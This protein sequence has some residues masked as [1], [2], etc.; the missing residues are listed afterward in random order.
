MSSSINLQSQ[1]ETKENLVKLIGLICNEY[2]LDNT[3]S[4]NIINIKSFLGPLRVDTITSKAKTVDD[5]N[6]MIVKLYGETI[7]S[8]R[9]SIPDDLN[10]TKKYLLKVIK[11]PGDNSKN[12]NKAY[13]DTFSDQK[14][15]F[16]ESMTGI[17]SILDLTPS[18]RIETMK[19]INYQSLFREEYIMID[20]RYQ[21]KVN[22][23]PTK[24]SFSLI[25]TTK[26]KSDHGGV[27]IGRPIKDI[28][29][30]EVYPFTIPYKPVYATFYN[31]ITLSINEWMSNS[32]EAYEGG[33]F[34][35][36][37]D[38]DKIDNN[39][40]YLK[41]VNPT[42]SFSSPVNYVDDF[43]LS[44]GAVF[45]KISFDPDRMFPSSI[46]YTNEYGL[47][48]FEEPHGLV[49]GDLIYITDFN[50]PESARDVAIISEVNRSEGHTIV[51]KDN[52]S[53]LINVDIT[54]VYN[55]NPI[56]SGIYPM[57]EFD[58][59]ALVFFAS[60]RIQIQMKL[61]YLTS[62]N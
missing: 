24:L 7:K 58:Q 15:G 59:K 48:I 61:R 54:S 8:N 55:E 4:T 53:I 21:N 51:K 41:P 14:E 22:S 25:G 30:I 39:L 38:I 29:E 9:S 44:F 43:T 31:K 56:G 33:Q 52:H 2:K 36:C 5:A 32:F 50:T 6:A 62:Y 34:H 60:K 10:S 37:F 23:D 47:F 49:T 20:S 1:I 46:D 35:F 40:I 26:T 18:Q 42:Y 16:K 45:P 12:S 11:T 17:G 19:Y 27:I 57:D 3:L 28:I 13:K